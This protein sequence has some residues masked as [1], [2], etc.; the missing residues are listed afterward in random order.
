M[1]TRTMS[2]GMLR[3]EV[4]TNIFEDIDPY[5]KRNYDNKIRRYYQPSRTYIHI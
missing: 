1:I 4:Q 2:P 5:L 3:K